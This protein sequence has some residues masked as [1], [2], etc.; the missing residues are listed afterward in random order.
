VPRCYR[1]AQEDGFSVPGTSTCV[2]WAPSPE[3]R[4]GFGSRAVQACHHVH[5][6]AARSCVQ[7]LHLGHGETLYAGFSFR[8]LPTGHP[9]SSYPTA[10]LTPLFGGRNV[11]NIADTIPFFTA[12]NCSPHVNILSS[13]G[14]SPTQLVPQDDCLTVQ[15]QPGEHSLDWIRTKR[16]RNIHRTVR[17]KSA[18]LLSGIWCR[19]VERR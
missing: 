5:S 13:W 9:H 11:K 4:G 2:T 16:M 7:E 3:P 12:S 1:Q 6:T 15:A 8:L 17:W 10:T 18:L 19:R 14:E